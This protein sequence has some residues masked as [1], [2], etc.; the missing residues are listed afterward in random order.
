MPQP[1]EDYV[2]I[3]KNGNILDICWAICESVVRNEVT[4]DIRAA[5]ETQVENEDCFWNEYTVS[6]FAIAA[7]YIIDKLTYTGERYQ[8]KQLVDNQ[9]AFAM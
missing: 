5:I 2:N 3:I 7:L 6:D 4:D 8:I 9:F 1:K